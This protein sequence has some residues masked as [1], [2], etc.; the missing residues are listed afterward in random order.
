MGPFELLEHSTV[1]FMIGAFLFS[2]VS[3]LQVAGGC[4]IWLCLFYGVVA[5]SFIASYI[6]F[7]VFNQKTPEQASLLLLSWTRLNGTLLEVSELLL[8]D[9]A[10]IF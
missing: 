3:R 4:P 10:D 6:L 7:F 8:R 9:H 1:L 5:V 2:L